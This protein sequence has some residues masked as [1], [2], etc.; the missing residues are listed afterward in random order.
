MPR[1]Q[2][3]PM[4]NCKI[5]KVFIFGDDSEYLDQKDKLDGWTFYGE[6]LND[7]K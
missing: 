2:L 4:P 5:N 6:E 7:Y 1:F 3:S